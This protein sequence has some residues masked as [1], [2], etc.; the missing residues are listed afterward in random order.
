M[1]GV[2]FKSTTIRKEEVYNIDLDESVT[3]NQVVNI[4]L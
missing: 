2:R 3:Y 4:K 1:L